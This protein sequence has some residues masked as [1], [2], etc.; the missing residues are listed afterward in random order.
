MEIGHALGG[1]FETHFRL[2]SI[3]LEA[4]EGAEVQGPAWTLP[5][6]VDRICS[7]IVDAILMKDPH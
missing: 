1:A 6:I 2:V 5:D 7:R 4:L 3:G